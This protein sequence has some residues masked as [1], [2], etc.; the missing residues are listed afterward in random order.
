MDTKKKEKAKK[1]IQELL[2][3]AG[4]KQ[5]KQRRQVIYVLYDLARQPLWV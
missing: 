4:R 3:S 2:S 1:D 5:P